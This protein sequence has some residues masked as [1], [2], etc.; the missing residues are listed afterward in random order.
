MTSRSMTASGHGQTNRPR[1]VRVCF[2][3]MNRLQPEFDETGSEKEASLE[4]KCLLSTSKDTSNNGALEKIS[5]PQGAM[6]VT[7][8]SQT[9]SKSLL[10]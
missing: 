9:L 3:S 4:P 8:L 2:T 6:V 5:R 7:E 1:Q 10:A